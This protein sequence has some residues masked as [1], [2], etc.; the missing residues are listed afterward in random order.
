MNRRKALPVTGCSV[1]AQLFPLLAI[2]LG[3]GDAIA[4]ST[5][6]LSPNK[7]EDSVVPAPAVHSRVQPRLCR[8]PHRPE[9]ALLD[10]LPE[11]P[12]PVPDMAEVGRVLDALPLFEV[13]P[14]D[15]PRRLV[16]LSWR[17]GFFA[18]QQRLDREQAR[19]L[20]EE[21]CLAEERGDEARAARLLTRQLEV[22]RRV[23]RSRQV[24]IELYRTVAD[25]I[26]HASPQR[27][28]ALLS[29]AFLLSAERRGAEARAVAERLLTEHPR[30]R[31]VHYAHLILAESLFDRGTA[32]R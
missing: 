11:P 27:E 3:P 13:L 28:H 10:R 30:S 17:A 14:V 2:A 5:A 24:A 7:A 16:L 23:R 15:D 6:R 9:L 21:R 8:D 12:A 25:L 19:E 18:E 22:E 4:G 1:V 32:S 31:L 20:A 29:L 26:P